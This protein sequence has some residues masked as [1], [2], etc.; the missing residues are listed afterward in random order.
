MLQPCQTLKVLRILLD[1][2]LYEFGC[3]HHPVNVLK[4][5][6]QRLI[7]AMN[8]FTRPQKSAVDLMCS[9]RQPLRIMLDLASL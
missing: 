8:V 5:T 7:S 2:W 6:G 3:P 4:D 1:G 9:K